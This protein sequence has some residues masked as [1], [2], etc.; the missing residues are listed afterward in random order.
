MTSK[1]SRKAAIIIA[2]LAI[3]PAALILY[4]RFNPEDSIF[5]PRC[6]FLTL[7]GLQ[8]PGCGSQR[9]IHQ[10]LNGNIGA[11]F[12]YNAIVVLAIPYISLWAIFSLIEDKYLYARK[13]KQKLYHGTAVYIVLII[14]VSFGIIRNII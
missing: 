2:L 11:A 6:I 7:T 4:S 5:F 3:L 13:L 10:L 8:C 14:I 9:A 1:S 12:R